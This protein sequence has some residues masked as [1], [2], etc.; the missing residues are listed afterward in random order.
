[1]AEARKR[2][3]PGEGR[4]AAAGTSVTKAGTKAATKAMNGPA[5]DARRATADE[6]VQAWVDALKGGS[7]LAPREPAA[8]RLA[9]WLDWTDAIALA[10]VMEAHG[11]SPGPGPGAG[12]AAITAQAA[13]RFAQGRDRLWALVVSGVR[14]AVADW[15]RVDPRDPA[16]LRLAVNQAQRQMEAGVGRLRSDLRNRLLQGSAAQREL[17]G[18]DAVLERA[19][20]ER[21]RHLL[22]GAGP[23]LARLGENADPSVVAQRLLHA[24]TAEFELRLQPLQG[25][26]QALQASEPT[27]S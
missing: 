24:L 13:D 2:R 25:L 7:P 6:V 10:G 27:H 15:A 8:V 14:D 18:I 17:A 4:S 5:T 19:L 11:G 9:Q 3:A 22:G 1:M 21:Q 20:V 12:A 16:V 26:L 23:R